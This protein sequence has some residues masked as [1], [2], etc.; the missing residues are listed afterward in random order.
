M[1][2]TMLLTALLASST[3]L[4]AEVLYENPLEDNSRKTLLLEPGTE[5]NFVL[6]EDGKKCFMIERKEQTGKNRD[7]IS[8]VIPKEKASN[9]SLLVT[10]DVKM[11]IRKPKHSWSGLYILPETFNP[12]WHTKSY[13]TQPKNGICSWKKYTFRVTLP[14][15]TGDLYLRIGIGDSVGTLKLRNLKVE[16][17]DYLIDLKKFA[18]RDF[19]DDVAGDSKGGWHDAGP[20]LDARN[21][22]IRQTRFANVQFKIIDPAKNKRNAVLV[23]DGPRSKTGLKTASFPIEPAANVRYVYLLH[24]SAWLDKKGTEIGRIIV[25]GK[26]GKKAEFPI[27]SGRDIADWWGGKGVENAVAGTYIS[28]SAG[29]GSPYVSR[30]EL[31]A[32]FGLV[33]GV[34]LKRDPDG[35]TIWMVIGL[36]LSEK[37]YELP[38]ASGLV[39]Q[40]NE[41]WKKLVEKQS[42]RQGTALDLSGFFP[43][44]EAG[45]FGRVVIGKNGQL[46]FEKNPGVPVRFFGANVTHL[47]GKGIS[48]IEVHS[49][50]DIDAIADQYARAGFNMV[51][52]WFYRL[53]VADNLWQ[54]RKAYEIPRANQER[55]D[56]LLYALKKRGIYVLL[57]SIAPLYPF[58]KINPWG[59]DFKEKDTNLYFNQRDREGQ[60]RFLHDL[61]THVNPH[62]GLRLMDD[63]QIIAIDF[64]N[65]Y[66][67]HAWQNKQKH[68]WN[69]AF[70]KFLEERYGTFEKLAEKWGKYAEGKKSFQE[71]EFRFMGGAEE[72][73]AFY[74]DRAEFVKEVY[75]DFYRDMRDYVR[76]IGYK[77]PC[78]AYLALPNMLLSGIR[79]SMD[80]VVKNG[81]HDHPQRVVYKRSGMMTQN[82]AIAS[83]ANYIRGFL[84]A[85]LYGKPLIHGEVTIPFFNKYRYEK[86]FTLGAYASLNSFAGFNVFMNPMTILPNEWIEWFD[87][88]HDPVNHASVLIEALL[89]RRMDVKPAN[90]GT[91]LKFDVNEV[92]RNGT[93]SNSFNTEQL[94]LGLLG[95]FSIDQ[96]AQPL[97]KNQYPLL[98]VGSAATQVRDWDFN[99]LDQKGSF[100]FGKTVADLKKRGFLK[101]E[102]RT[103]PANDIYESGTGEIYMDAGNKLMRI[104]TPRFQGVCCEADVKTD[105]PEFRV[106]SNNRRGCFALTSIDGEKSIREAKRLLLFS[107]TNALNSKMIFSD[108]EQRD[109]LNRGTTPIL[110]ETGTFEFEIRT[111]NAK[112]MSA[113]ALNVDGTRMQ[114][115][116]LEQTPDGVRVKMENAKWKVPSFYIELAE[117]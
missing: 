44:A 98:P 48:K 11:D 110:V 17:D 64:N 18:N 66:D 16:S 30:F 68:Y 112:K 111:P 90:F 63:P 116:P 70:R 37:K 94:K 57:S 104:N 60:K 40:E 22:P 74:Q 51:R 45:A 77:G 38:K 106:L 56:Y 84:S 91:R 26:D 89:Y 97:Q 33:N 73:G 107:V 28:C 69:A 114:E 46:E 96:T 7:R 102:N 21:F 85:K 2:K 43:K 72:A 54:T 83:S 4:F 8:C 61:L 88:R 55:M 12:Y 31:P 100:D 36:T 27:V 23:F 108:S 75:V 67:G 109:C 113:W 93:A 42:I 52:I 1:K 3:M 5:N 49:R 58:P 41:I 24:T 10:V 29:G 19:K 86:G 79:D 20:E 25:T 47:V 117:K 92:I 9:K 39:T 78:T 14:Q 81:Y 32:D 6:D 50:A 115:L 99:V 105:L 87:Q 35:D 103:D 76:S 59:K 82:S 62:T 71:I 34:E 80:L 15:L 101:A 65:E 95:E 13:T 53:L